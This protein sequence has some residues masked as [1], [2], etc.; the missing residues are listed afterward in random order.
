VEADEDAER[1]ICITGDDASEVADVSWTR[2]A[3][4]H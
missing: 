4:L 1:N 2:V 3:R